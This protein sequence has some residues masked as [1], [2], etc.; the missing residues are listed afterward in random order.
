ML[1]NY[2]DQIN[3]LQTP[4]IEKMKVFLQ[5]Y[6]ATPLAIS[7]QETPEQLTA[8]SALHNINVD[9]RLKATQMSQ[10]ETLQKLG[11]TGL[12]PDDMAQLN[13]M[14]RTTEGDVASRSAAQLQEQSRRGMGG[15]NAS[16]AAR[17]IEQQGA[18]NRQSDQTENQ[19]AIAFKRM[20]DAKASAGNLAGQMSSADFAQQ[21]QVAGADE[22]RALQN[23]YQ[24]SGTQQ[25]NID[26][27]NQANQA[28]WANQQSTADKNVGAANQNKY[29][30]SNLQ[31]QNY[32]NQLKRLGLMG[33]ASQGM[34]NAYG[35]QANRTAA[36]W[37]G[38]GAGI[39]QM[40]MG[41]AQQQQAQ[42]NFDSAMDL[43]KKKAGLV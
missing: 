41:M 1:Q 42:N 26:R 12:S 36:M 17:L 28:N 30:T 34:A 2:Y 37:S 29:Y 5:Q 32:D 25:R 23:L 21:A 9:P 4:D 6:Q 39:G 10:L 19:A 33:G 18:A 8:D 16:L 20:L 7:Q 38:A 11:E 22:S 3:G 40:G 35:D 13:R 14:R 31:Q 15:S 27:F 24:R 43:Q